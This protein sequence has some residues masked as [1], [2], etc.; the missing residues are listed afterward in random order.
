M[1][2][3]GPRQPK[4]RHAHALDA[5]A[6]QH[7]T[8]FCFEFDHPWLCVR[9][10]SSPQLPIT[11][12]LHLQPSLFVLCGSAVMGYCQPPRDLGAWAVEDATDAAEESEV[13]LKTFAR[14]T[15]LGGDLFGWAFS[16]SAVTWF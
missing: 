10:G 2:S 16:P 9:P 8:G 4:A 5:L 6:I 7:Q 13:P 3:A 12:S 15:G 14:F 1:C 11:L